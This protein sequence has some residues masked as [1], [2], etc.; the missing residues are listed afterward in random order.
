MAVN[1]PDP[2]RNLGHKATEASL[3]KNPAGRMVDYTNNDIGKQII[4]E[5]QRHTQGVYG[6]HSPTPSGIST[7]DNLQAWSKYS[8]SNSYTGHRNKAGP[9]KEPPVSDDS[10]RLVPSE[11]RNKDS[12]GYLES[13]KNWPSFEYGS[14]SGLG[15]IEKT[16]RK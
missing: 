15:R 5:G 2:V 13:T 1:R 12:D 16:H 6:R 11:A 10:R 3:T 4:R 9:G 14:D 7:A 8:T